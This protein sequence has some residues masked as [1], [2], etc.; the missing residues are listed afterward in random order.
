V[1]GKE[2]TMSDQVTPLG[3]HF[4]HARSPHR[5]ALPFVITHGWPGSIVGFLKVIEP[6]VDPPAH[7]C[8]G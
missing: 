2:A 6:L 7:G 8:F 4:I 5:D 3:I 1:F